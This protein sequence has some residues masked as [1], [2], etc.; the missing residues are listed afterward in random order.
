MGNINKVIICVGMALLFFTSEMK[1][2]VAN[3]DPDDVVN[4]GHPDISRLERIVEYQEISSQGQGVYV[5]CYDGNEFLMTFSR[6][7]STLTQVMEFKDNTSGKYT[8]PKE[9]E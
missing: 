7:Y 2:R 4:Q 6:G 5:V 8:A 3:A 9:C 1:L